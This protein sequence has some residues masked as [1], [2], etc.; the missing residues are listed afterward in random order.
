MKALK[1]TTLL[2][3][4]FIQSL[5]YAQDGI[6]PNDLEGQATGFRNDTNSDEGLFSMESICKKLFET[7]SFDT[8]DRDKSGK[9][10]AQLGSFWIHENILYYTLKI[11]NRSNINYDIDFIRFYVRDLK[12]AKRTVTQ[13]RELDPAYSYGTDDNTIQG[14]GSGQFVFA[15]EKFPITKDQAFFIEIYEK[16]GGRH[17]YLKAKQSHIE[18]AKLFR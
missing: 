10:S 17:L 13:E 18:N 7:R 14:Q 11:N 1:V 6:I 8:K 5:V 4:Y 15:L 2:L 12:T 3:L 16:N 9:A